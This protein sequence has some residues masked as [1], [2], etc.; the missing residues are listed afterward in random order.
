MTIIERCGVIALH[1]NN[2]LLVKQRAYPS[3]WGIPKG[4][5]EPTEEYQSGA[6]REMLEETGIDV[7][8]LID[9]CNYVH[10]NG[11]FYIVYMPEMT[12]SISNDTNEIECM[13]WIPIDQLSKYNLNYI[14]REALKE[15]CLIGFNS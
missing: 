15:S 12:M 13:K 11:R 3:K 14:T 8:P 7:T 4:S 1:G 2:I 5:K 9:P 10:K 6:V